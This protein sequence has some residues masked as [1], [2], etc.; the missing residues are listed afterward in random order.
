MAR[1]HSHVGYAEGE[2]RIAQLIDAFAAVKRF[3][4]AEVVHALTT[5][6]EP[7]GKKLH[8]AASVAITLGT[9]NASESMIGC[10]VECKGKDKD[11]GKLVGIKLKGGVQIGDTSRLSSEG[12]CC[13]D[14][15]NTIISYRR[16]N[17]PIGDILVFCK[18]PALDPTTFRVVQ[19]DEDAPPSRDFEAGC[20]AMFDPDADGTHKF[21]PFGTAGHRSCSTCGMHGPSPQS[22]PDYCRK[23]KLCHVCCKKAP[24]CSHGS[25]AP[26]PTGLGG[27]GGG[28]PMC[29]VCGVQP[30]DGR[31]HGTCGAGCFHTLRAG[32]NST[33]FGQGRA[34]QW[35][36]LGRGHPSLLGAYH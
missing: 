17:V 21:V 7:T 5:V 27:G 18:P 9:E 25:S 16:Q 1:L 30:V 35:H 36:L 26:A 33:G 14:F 6:H 10:R 13:V 29:I 28:V 15:E 8:P 34:G 32:M 4:R 31:G 11:K 23:C 22:G 19:D 12:V 24:Q 3:S 20:F 2:A